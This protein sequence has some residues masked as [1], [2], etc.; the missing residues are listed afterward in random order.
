MFLFCAFVLLVK[1]RPS[2]AISSI[3][4]S[5]PDVINVKQLSNVIEKNHVV[6][7]DS[8]EKTALL[9]PVSNSILLL[10]RRDDPHTSRR[11]SELR[12]QLQCDC[13]DR[14]KV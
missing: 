6:V 11:A 9:T 3:E 4:T 1:W 2:A 12:K 13:D 10:Y 8:K 7:S 5:I 14:F